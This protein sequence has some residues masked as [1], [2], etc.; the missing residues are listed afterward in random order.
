MS[1]T[2][3]IFSSSSVSAWIRGLS[4][5]FWFMCAQPIDSEWRAKR[6]CSSAWSDGSHSAVHALFRA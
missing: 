6:V 3:R 1:W 4:K 2:D 5:S